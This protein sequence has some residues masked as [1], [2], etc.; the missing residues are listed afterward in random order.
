MANTEIYVPSTVLRAYCEKS[1]NNPAGMAGFS[2]L[3]SD[4]K[5]EANRG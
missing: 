1:C 2:F 4:E 5:T 3:L